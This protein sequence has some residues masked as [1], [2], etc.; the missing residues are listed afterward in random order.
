[1]AEIKKKTN[2]ISVIEIW[3]WPRDN[4]KFWL[5]HT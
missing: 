4:I 2:K 1:M 5:Q 3:Y